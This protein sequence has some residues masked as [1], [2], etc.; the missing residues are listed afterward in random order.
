MPL[1]RVADTET[2]GLE[3]P[4]ELVEIGWTDV[5]NNGDGWFIAG[6]WESRLVDP[7]MPITFGAMA[8]HHITD[9]MV[10][11]GMDP[12]QARALLS[13]G[14]DVIA[15][16]NWKFDSRFVRTER[17]VICTYKC[18]MTLWP[19]LQSHKNG[20]IRYERGYCLGDPLAE[21]AHRAGPDSWI[22]AHI[23]L[24]MLETHRAN[25]LVKISRNPVLLKKVS[26]GDHIGKLW[27]EVDDGL[28]GWVVRK[29]A[30]DPNRE[31][32]VFTAQYEIDRRAGRV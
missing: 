4:A 5:V 16:H 32:E 3:D 31:D 18:A 21:P 15:A 23:L 13:D 12:D 14:A 29:M 30:G 7:W 11:D 8:T 2:T 10:R 17:P 6:P 24:D 20:A 25:D 9:E 19:D 28:L 1:I 26:F 22:T 27:S